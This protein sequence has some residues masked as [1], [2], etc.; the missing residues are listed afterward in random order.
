MEKARAAEVRDSGKRRNIEVGKAGVR[1][2]ERDTGGWEER[3]KWDYA[4]EK[5]FL[6]NFLILTGAPLCALTSEI[7]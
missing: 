2:G 1:A 7:I 6:D 4:A 3:K 5:Q